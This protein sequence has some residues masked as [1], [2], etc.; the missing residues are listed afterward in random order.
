MILSHD[1]RYEGGF[2]RSS[3][4][5]DVVVLPLDVGGRPLAGRVGV[6]AGEPVVGRVL[7]VLQGEE[8]ENKA[9]ALITLAGTMKKSKGLKRLFLLHYN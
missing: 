6:R 5:R 1:T 7:G 4:G 2:R 9:E 8:V 3:C